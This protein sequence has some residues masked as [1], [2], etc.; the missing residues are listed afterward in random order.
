M[1]IEKRLE[2]ITA[3]PAEEIITQEDLVELLKTNSAPVAYDGFEPSGLLHIA[4]GLMRAAKIQD[5]TEAGV[6]FTLLVADWHGYINNKMGGDLEKIQKVGKYF[7]HGWQACGVDP[8]KIEIRWASEAVKDPEY[9]KLVLAVARH[10]TLK[11][12]QRCLTIMGRQEGELKETIALFYPAMQVADIFY[13]DVDICQLGLDQR[14][15]NMLAREIAPALG[16]KKPVAVHHHM[17]AGLAGPAAMGAEFDEEKA[18]SSQIEN[19]MSKSKPS[20]SIYIHD[21]PEIVR[22]KINAAYCPEKMV[23]GNPLL[24]ISKY[25]L[26]KKLKE[27]KIERPAKF[28]GPVAFASYG[29][30]EEAYRQGLHPLDLKNGVAEGLVQLLEP[31]NRYFSGNREAAELLEFVKS[32]E[33]TR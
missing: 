13:L 15:A 7:V 22:K 19:K 33:V 24:E 16:K 1:D 3:P 20:G 25:I 9:W 30:L 12:M 2:L 31:V 23:E 14:R 11:R 32:A 6:K 10:T 5:M 29:E 8:K 28:G 18:I 27:L 17:L 26:F 21:T 4:S